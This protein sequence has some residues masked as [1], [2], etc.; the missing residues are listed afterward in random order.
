MI[1]SLNIILPIVVLIMLIGSSMHEHV[2]K[3]TYYFSNGTYILKSQDKKN[4]N[5]L[6]FK[7]VE[8]EQQ[9]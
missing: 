2:Y 7:K 9:N 8:Y 5:N 4:N 6:K 3:E 1:V